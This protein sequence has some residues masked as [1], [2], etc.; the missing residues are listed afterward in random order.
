MITNNVMLRL[1]ER[2][3][4]NIQKAR[5]ILLSMKGKIEILRDIKVEVAIHEGEYD[6]LLITKFDSME[7]LNNYQVHPV[8]LEVQKHIL[9]VLKTA[10]S[11]CYESMD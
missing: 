2:S 8:H 9:S 11:L 5:N 1:E 6:I 7:D 3:N 4:E 10:A